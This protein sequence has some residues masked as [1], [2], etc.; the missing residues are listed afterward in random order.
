MK[1]LVLHKNKLYFSLICLLCL[2][3]GLVIGRVTKDPLIIRSKVLRE[4]G[5]TYINPVLLCNT[6]NQQAYNENKILSKKLISYVNSHT[7]ND[8]S[9][10]FLGLSGGSWASINENET[11]SPASMLKVQTMVDALKY[12]E[13]NPNILSKQVYYDGSFDNNKAEYFKPQK[14][15]EAGKYYTIDQLI[16]YMITYSD[17]N[18]AK[19]LHD[20]IDSQSLQELYKDLSIEIPQNTIDFMNAKTYAL[21]LRVLYN[22]TYLNREMSEKALKLMLAPDFPV[23]LQAGIDPKIEIA[24]KFGERQIFDTK[25]NLLKREL[26]DCGII[27]K[28]KTPYILCVMTRG[29]DFQKMATSIKDVSKIVY[30]DL[31][32]Q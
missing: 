17:N 27:Y 25:G 22:S 9:V 15:L 1:T 12:A 3:V 20:N 21:F 5:Y 19:L 32:E 13:S 28:D 26:H 8:I 16:Q 6:D 24:Q 10:Y 23:G 7:E 18:A 30:D 31:N 14:S 11:Y 29:D 4:S 2:G